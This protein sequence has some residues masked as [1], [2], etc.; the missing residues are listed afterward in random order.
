MI[1]NAVEYG[2]N[3]NDVLGAIGLRRK[4]KNMAEQFVIPEEDGAISLQEGKI[5]ENEQ[6]D[7]PERGRVLY[8][9]TKRPVYKMPADATVAERRRMAVQAMRDE[10]TWPWTAAAP[11]TYS[12]KL[13]CSRDYLLPTD[14]VFSGLPYT[15]ASSSLF[16]WL[17]CMDLEKGELKNSDMPRVGYVM[18]NA[19][20]PSVGWGQG[21]VCPSVGG[22]I[23]GK[24]YTPAN[25]YQILGGLKYPEG[26]DGEL[27]YREY[28][29]RQIIADNG[30][31]KAM[32]GLALALPGDAVVCS[33]DFTGTHVM[34]VTAPAHVV[35]REDGTLDALA[36]FLIVQDQRSQEYPVVQDAQRMSRR[37]RIYKEVTFDYLSRYG[38]MA[39]SPKE[40][41]ENRPYVPAHA[42]LSTG[43][44]QI[45]KLSETVLRS[46]YRM[47]VLKLTLKD[48]EGRTLFCSRILPH[49]E[50]EG[51]DN[52]RRYYYQGCP[53]T[54]F[55]DRETLDKLAEGYPTARVILSVLVATGEEFV[56]ES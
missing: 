43:S 10:L 2:K 38:F 51:E 46:N 20:A 24:R 25:G 29:T 17:D 34:M 55:A 48:R 52:G 23:I 54:D 18:G 6:E 14:Q 31:E 44:L 1:K 30:L 19:C 9:R 32:E 15:T 56:F 28:S 3:L 16:A 35:R 40:W 49:A 7:W 22:G 42:E 39:V 27:T 37:G 45:T 13:A 21:A 11:I 4:D 53:L 41:Q 12:K 33:G 8:P 36:S 47:A 50:M 5:A 26:L